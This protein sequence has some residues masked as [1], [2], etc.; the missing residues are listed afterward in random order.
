MQR[1]TD[2]RDAEIAIH[3]FWQQSKVLITLELS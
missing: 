2:Q 1:Q 3:I